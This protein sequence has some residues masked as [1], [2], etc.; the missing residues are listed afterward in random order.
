M[1]ILNSNTY[2]IIV[3]GSG[4]GGEGAAMQAAKEQ[5]KVAIIEKKKSIGGNCTHLGTIPSKTLRFISQ[6]LSVSH[7]S[8]Y[9]N[10]QDRQLKPN[11]SQ[12]LIRAQNVI[13]KQV[14][15]R[16]SH[17]YRNNVKIYR[18]HARITD[19]E[20]V[21]IY[22]DK[23]KITH[24]LKAKHII[25]ATG[26]KPNRPKEIDFNCTH[27]FDS[28]TIL[29][30]KK[31]PEK[32][33]IYG[34]GVIGCEYASIFRSLGAKVTLINPHK[35][36]L[37]FLDN[38]IIDALSYHFRDQGIRIKHNENCAKID[39]KEDSLTMYLSSGKKITANALLV[40]KG[41]IGALE[42]LGNTSIATTKKNHIK[43]NEYYQSSKPNIY[44]VGDITG[45][46]GLASSAYD[47]GRFAA[48]HII[49]PIC[50]PTLLCDMPVGIFTNPEISC[51][52]SSEEQLTQ[53]KI[54]YE[55][56]RVAFKN[57]A[58]SQIENKTTGML[59]LIFHQED[60]KILGV[61]CFGHNASEIVHIGQ[62]IMAQ[63][64]SG[65]SLRYF[66]NTTFNYP[67][68]AEAYRVAAL[69]GLNRLKS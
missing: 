63:K 25:I 21:T 17:Y 51:L 16:S 64:S 68:M 15:R 46:P 49:N 20:T 24:K 32:I 26:S 10:N 6:H 30:L 18:G 60:L 37:H 62:A 9:E 57:L 69:N 33:I 54:P 47:Q 66:I 7:N 3:I 14:Q 11:F 59:K 28:D 34:A 67:T 50:E 56:G 43:V 38:E 61:H 42:A 2:D 27:V 45:T 31:T 1:S 44:A 5:L 55:T 36:I 65:N 53:A 58:R 19:N 23:N 40:T 35:Q 48:L 39:Y 41:R 8:I 4:P 13:Q 12:I 29:Q 52:G 22:D